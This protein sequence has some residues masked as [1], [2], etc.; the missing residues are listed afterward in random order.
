MDWNL[1]G[2]ARRHLTYAPDEPE[3]RDRLLL[4]TPAGEAWR[5]LRCGTYVLGAAMGN[6]PADDA[7]VPR[8]GRELRDAIV[9]RLLGLERALRAVVILGAAYAVWTFRNEKS[10][11]QHAFDQNLPLLR[12][13]ADRL[14]WQLSDSSVVHEV[15]HLLTISQTTLLLIALVLVVYAAVE[16]VECAGLM[17]LRRW[18]EYFAVVATSAFIPF[19]VYELI[20]EQTWLRVI[21]L[22]F[23]I[24]VVVYIVVAKRLFGARGGLRAYEEE[25]ASARIMDLA[26]TSETR[27]PRAA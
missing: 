21:A 4:H 15:R 12:P 16:A 11:L 24:A 22:V 19:E 14:G 7:P 25:R 1:L 3:F 10:H 20:D 5:C 18:G 2:C 9:L 8:R 17:S 26:E 23:N 13:I 6:G 27:H